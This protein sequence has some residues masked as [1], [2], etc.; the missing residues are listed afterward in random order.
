VAQAIPP[1]PPLVLVGPLLRQAQQHLLTGHRSKHQ[2]SWP[3][4]APWMKAYYQA[5]CLLLLL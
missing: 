2:V 4:L 1:E 5:L 3:L